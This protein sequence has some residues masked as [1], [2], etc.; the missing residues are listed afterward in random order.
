M[1]DRPLLWITGVGHSGTSVAWNLFR[2]LG[3]TK[4]WGQEWSKVA[5]L[6]DEMVRQMTGGQSLHTDW[7]YHELDFKGSPDTE[8]LERFRDT[9]NALEWP[10]VVKDPRWCYT[11]GAWLPLVQPRHLLICLRDLEQATCGWIQQGDFKLDSA[12][13]A[14][15]EKAVYQRAAFV[16]HGAALA[17]RNT[18]VEIKIIWYPDFGNG[19]SHP[20]F[21]EWVA[22]VLGTRELS[23]KPEYGEVSSVFQEL[24]D[25][26]AVHWR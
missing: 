13:L 8:F 10:D 21:I 5:D 26:E 19:S 25:H 15:V 12:S 14:D 1:S 6:N 17:L 20:N 3:A 7:R 22:D 24:W 4:A 11:L 18:D 2:R 9:V 23:R 16:M